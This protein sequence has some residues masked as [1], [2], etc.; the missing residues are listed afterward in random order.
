MP[1]NQGSAWERVELKD[2]AGG[3]NKYEADLKLKRDEPPDKVWLWKREDQIFYPQNPGERWPG[4][5]LL[6]V[7]PEQGFLE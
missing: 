6:P 1:R 7:I 2:M 5:N 3:I 4:L